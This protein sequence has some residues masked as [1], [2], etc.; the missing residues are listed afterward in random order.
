[1]LYVLDLSVRADVI[2]F[3]YGNPQMFHSPS[4]I[5]FNAVINFQSRSITAAGKCSSCELKRDTSGSK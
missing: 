3:F 5:M 2:Q 1:M 4:C